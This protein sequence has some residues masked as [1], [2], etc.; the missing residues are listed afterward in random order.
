MA[1]LSARLVTIQRRVD[2]AI[3]TPWVTRRGARALVLVALLLKLLASAWNAHAFD[4]LPYDNTH[5]RTRAS[6]GGLEI[7][8][9]AYDPPLYYI[10][11]LIHVEDRKAGKLEAGATTDDLLQTLRYT[12]VA[13]LALFYCCWLYVIFPRLVRNWRAATIASLIL[14]ALPG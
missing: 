5:H 14:L 9:L 12:N 10:P 4:G 1:R 8:D 3:R 11:A 13:Y 2:L 7:D 6:H